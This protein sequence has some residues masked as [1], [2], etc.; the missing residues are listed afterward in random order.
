MCAATTVY[1]AWC[2][3]IHNTLTESWD[4]D[5]SCSTS[6]ASFCVFKIVQVSK[7]SKLVYK[8]VPTSIGTKL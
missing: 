3:L 1:P 2:W 5:Y 8:Y 7:L 6:N 4:T